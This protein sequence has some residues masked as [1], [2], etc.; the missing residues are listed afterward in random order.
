[1]SEI[2]SLA[3]LAGVKVAF[4]GS[5][6]MGEAM[7]AGLL[8]RGLVGPTQIVASH[9]RADR[10]EQL[11]E[12]YGISVAESNLDAAR[13]ADREKEQQKAKKRGKT[14]P[15]DWQA[16]TDS[17]DALVKSG[18]FLPG[19]KLLIADPAKHVIDLLD[20]LGF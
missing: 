8:A 16:A 2:D 11:V 19:Q 6:V 20:P 17:L 3:P 7:L 1:M 12:R 10:R 18:K 14:P 13:K 4:V 15:P 5:G 9:P